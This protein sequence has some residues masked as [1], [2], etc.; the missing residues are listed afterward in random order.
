MDEAL[1]RGDTR[2]I[3]FLNKNLK[4]AHLSDES[5]ICAAG[6]GRVE[7]IRV[8]PTEV[9]LFAVEKRLDALLEN[10]LLSGSSALL[11]Y[12]F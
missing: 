2:C 6:S 5:A 4:F 3:R 11:A 7:V 1:R 10:A 12:L 8:L 9:I